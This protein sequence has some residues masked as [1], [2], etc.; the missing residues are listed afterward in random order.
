MSVNKSEV[1]RFKDGKYGV[2]RLVEGSKGIPSLGYSAYE[3]YDFSHSSDGRPWRNINYGPVSKWVRTRFIR[4]AQKASERWLI[5]LNA[6]I[7]ILDEGV[8]IET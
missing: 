4:K 3:Y 1:V 2:R 7:P 8:P 6:E 5:S